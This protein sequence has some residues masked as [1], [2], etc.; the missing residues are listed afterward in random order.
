MIPDIFVEEDS[1]VDFTHPVIDSLCFDLFD[2]IE[3]DVEKTRAAYHFVRDEIPHSFDI[4]SDLVPTKASDVLLA[5]TG[6]C[7][8]KANLLAAILRHENI[9]AGFCFEHITL[10]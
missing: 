8:S 2:G 6:I 7:H 1:Y 10:A 5:G 4:D 9:P 3:D